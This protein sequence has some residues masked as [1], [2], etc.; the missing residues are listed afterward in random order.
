MLVFQLERDVAL[1]AGLA[2]LALVERL[3]HA[4]PAQ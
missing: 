4:A 1:Q 2:G 3:G